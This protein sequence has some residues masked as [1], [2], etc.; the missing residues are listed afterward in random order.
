MINF[1]TV[2]R[3]AN[4]EELYY[5]EHEGYLMP[6]DLSAYKDKEKGIWVISD[7]NTGVLVSEGFKKY[8]DLSFIYDESNV[9]ERL[10]QV[11]KTKFYKTLRESYQKAYK[12]HFE[13][14]L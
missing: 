8:A 2:K 5:E 4:S 9:M 7:A 13:S 11:R 6:C 14:D 1:L 10:E 3:K 12:E